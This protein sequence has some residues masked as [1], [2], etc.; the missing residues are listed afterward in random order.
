M[1]RVFDLLIRQIAEL[2]LEESFVVDVLDINRRHIRQHTR[3]RR[4]DT[5]D[6]DDFFRARFF[7]RMQNPVEGVA[8]QRHAV[9]GKMVARTEAHILCAGDHLFS[10]FVAD[11]AGKIA[12]NDRDAPVDGSEAAHRAF[13]RA[14]ESG[15]RRPR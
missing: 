7:Q 4:G 1:W 2:V 13:N 12:C 5:V 9:V 15:T 8:F 6:V 14:A 10:H 3:H 11:T